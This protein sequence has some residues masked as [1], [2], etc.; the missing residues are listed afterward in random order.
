M[1]EKTELETSVYLSVGSNL[2]DRFSNIESAISLIRSRIGEISKIAPIYENPPLGFE[3]DTLFYNSC[4]LV[5]TKLLPFEVLEQIQ[6]IEKE[7]G[8]THKTDNK[9]YSSRII[10][11][12]IIF[13]ESEIVNED[14]LIIPHPLFK[15]RRFV[16]LPLN[17]VGSDLIDPLTGLT[18]SQ[19]LAICEDKSILLIVKKT[20]H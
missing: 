3:A 19:L 16:L 2:G 12:D 10:D 20:I 8:R 13:Y 7:L 17:D 18:V 11:I 6:N 15:Y 1:E 9:S 5:K 14:K 4:L